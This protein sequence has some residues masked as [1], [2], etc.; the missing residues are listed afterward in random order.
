MGQL[1][2]TYWLV[3]YDGMPVIIDQPAHEKILYENTMKSLKPGSTTQMV[4]P[5]HHSDA[6]MNEE[7]L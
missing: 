5:S 7:L 1:F 6:G 3:E 4:N 2:D